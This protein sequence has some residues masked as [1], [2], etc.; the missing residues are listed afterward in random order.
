MNKP[1]VTGILSYGMSGKVFHAPFVNAHQGFKL[2]AITERSRKEA[3]ETYP[4]IKSY[5]SV[6]ELIND[7]AI[8]LVI[9]NTPNYTHF[10]YAEKALLAG[11][12]VLVEK[13]F[14]ATSAEAKQLFDLARKVGKKIFP[15]QNRRWDSDF[16]S[17]RE[18]VESGQLGKLIEVHLRFDRYR[19]AIGPKTFK[20]TPLPGSGLAYDLGAHLL[21]QAITLFG[22]PLSAAKA[23]GIYRENSQVDDYVNFHLIFSN[24]I[25]VFVTTSLLVANPLPSFVIHGSRGSFIK[26]R[27]DVQEDQL[28]QGISPVAENYGIEPEDKGG[29]LA[30]IDR[31]G[32][33]NVIIQNRLKG[34]YMQLWEKVFRNIRF[35]ENYPIKEDEIIWQ[36]EI[37]EQKS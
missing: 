3:S 16:L 12:H 18:V 35:E 25:N 4:S 21:D 37:L 29:V 36:L 8:E 19:S 11:K 10:E 32:N 17:I 27:T 23:T 22:K 15:F 9:V 1:I 5:D 24:Q 6:D 20:E 2:Y 26:E 34:D 14:V 28:L 30:L 13:P 31:E 7:P 33:K